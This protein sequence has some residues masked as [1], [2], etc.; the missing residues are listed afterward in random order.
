MQLQIYD[1]TLREGEQAAGA[2]PTL[3]DRKKIFQALDNAGIHLIEIG[4]PLHKP[5]MELLS[6]LEENQKQKAVVRRAD[7]MRNLFCVSNS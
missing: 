4:W 5:V 3:E 6:Q 7:G 1:C 2:S